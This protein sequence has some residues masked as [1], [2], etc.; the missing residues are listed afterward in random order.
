MSAR[1]LD[2]PPSVSFYVVIGLFHNMSY[3]FQGVSQ[4]EMV[5]TAVL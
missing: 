3:D 1:V 4:E 5:E 2:S